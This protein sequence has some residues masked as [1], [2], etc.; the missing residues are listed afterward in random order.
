MNIRKQKNKPVTSYSAK[1]EIDWTFVALATGLTLFFGILLVLMLIGFKGVESGIQYN[2][3]V[4][5]LF[6][7]L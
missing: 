4:L 6:R 5:C 1:Q 7:T 3:V 2:E